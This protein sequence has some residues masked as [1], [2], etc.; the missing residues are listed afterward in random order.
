MFMDI[1][2][3]VEIGVCFPTKNLKSQ[4][5]F[6]EMTVRREESPDHQRTKSKLIATLTPSALIH[7]FPFAGISPRLRAT[8]FWTTTAF[9]QAEQN[10]RDFS[11]GS[12]H[13]R[14]SSSSSILAAPS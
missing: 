8:S 5:R 11:L 10:A 7:L 3:H 2:K 12:K 14:S 6:N 13:W 4:G 9:D 1:P